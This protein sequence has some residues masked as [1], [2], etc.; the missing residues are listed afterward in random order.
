MGEKRA[1]AVFGHCV[2]H[3]GQM[4]QESRASLFPLDNHKL[5]YK[6]KRK[7]GPTRDP[8]VIDLSGAPRARGTCSGCSRNRGGQVCLGM[9]PCDLARGLLHVEG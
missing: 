1:Q 6:H 3:I 9:R 8:G 7:H 5:M 2:W 4:T